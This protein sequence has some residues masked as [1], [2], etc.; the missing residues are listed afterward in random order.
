MIFKL[1]TLALALALSCLVDAVTG[2]RITARDDNNNN[3]HRGVSFTYFDDPQ[4]I[5]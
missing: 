3:T 5:L 1:L 2:L 4:P